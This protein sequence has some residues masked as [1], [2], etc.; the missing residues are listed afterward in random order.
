M[1]RIREIDIKTAKNLTDFDP[2]SGKQLPRTKDVDCSPL[3]QWLDLQCIEE[4]DA[5]LFTAR[6]YDGVTR[7]D[8]KQLAEQGKMLVFTSGQ[9]AYFASREV[10]KASQQKD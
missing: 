1:L 6:F 7:D 10:V 5:E 4:K 2:E 9:Y 8:V 3:E